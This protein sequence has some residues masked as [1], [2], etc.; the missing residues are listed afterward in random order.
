M[1]IDKAGKHQRPCDIDN[2]VGRR[3]D[4]RC[5]SQ[6]SRAFDEHIAAQIADIRI[7]GHQPAAAK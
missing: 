4:L 2:F 6:D 5:Y 7:L 3:V 1:G